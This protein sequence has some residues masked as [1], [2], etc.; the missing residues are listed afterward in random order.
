MN[1]VDAI[2]NKARA[3]LS[4]VLTNG[5]EDIYLWEHAE[6]V[7]HT[8]DRIAQLPELRSRQIDELALAA[9]ALYH[10]VAWK[11]RY[12]EGDITQSD[13]LARQRSETHREQSASFM[14]QS[15][16]DLLEADS[17]ARASTAIR[18]M[19][20]RDI[21][22]IEGQVLNE[23]ENLS[24]I[25]ALSLWPIIRRGSVEGKGIQ[26]AI[27]TWRRQKEYSFWTAH[28][29]HSFR[30]DQVKEL[31]RRR[32]AGMEQIMEE[33]ARQHACADLEI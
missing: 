25:G 22:S 19:N 23:A 6:L 18:S 17:L 7:A 16:S 27:D 3:D 28:I 26:S 15:L 1:K 8:A 14:E 30:F 4:I 5:E 10:D 21:R 11:L 33:I 20:E 12:H 13:I 24:S 29:D 2:W 31:A 9:A 32:L